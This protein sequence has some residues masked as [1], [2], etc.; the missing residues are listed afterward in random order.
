MTVLSKYGENEK[1]SIRKSTINGKIKIEIQK[2]K[3]SV[4]NK[5]KT[6]SKISAKNLKRKTLKVKAV[7]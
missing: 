7:L 1:E 6:T 2:F 4:R 3:F 5:I